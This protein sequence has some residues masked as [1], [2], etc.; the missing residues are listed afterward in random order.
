MIRKRK[1][2]NLKH[3]AKHP[4][5]PFSIQTLFQEFSMSHGHPNPTCLGFPVN[6][7][8]IKTKFLVQ[9]KSKERERERLRVVSKAKVTVECV[10]DL[11]LQYLFESF[12]V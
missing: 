4:P 6:S 2:R 11:L 5:P 12:G 7:L 3:K 9:P 10:I 8:C 1:D